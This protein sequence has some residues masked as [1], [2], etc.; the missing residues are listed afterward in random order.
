MLQASR[1]FNLQRYR[2]QLAATFWRETPKNRLGLY[3]CAL[4]APDQRMQVEVELLLLCTGR[5]LVL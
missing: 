3:D 2:A 1:C 4:R 5:L